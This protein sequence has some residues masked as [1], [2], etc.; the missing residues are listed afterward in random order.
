MLTMF[1]GDTTI[2]V[3]ITP[4]HGAPSQQKKLKDRFATDVLYTGTR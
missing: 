3:K 4:W 2:K 1:L